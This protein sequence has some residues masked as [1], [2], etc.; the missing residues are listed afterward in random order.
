[1]QYRQLGASSLN[2]SE[3]SL[4]SWRTFGTAIEA[5]TAERC[6][7]QAFDCGINF[8]DTANMYGKGAAEQ[9]LGRLLKAYRRDDY[10]LATKLYFP[11]SETDR[12]LSRAQVLKQIDASLKRL[13]VDHVDLYQC[14]RHDGE[15]PLKETM[16]ALTEIVRAGKVRYVG[17]SEWPAAEIKRAR[18]IDGVVPF[19]SSQ[20]RYSMLYR[21]N[22]RRIFPLCREQ[23]IGQIVWSPLAQG[24]LTGKY[25]PGAA[26]PPGS[27]GERRSLGRFF[28]PRV[29]QAVE[30]LH[31]IARDL[32]LTL[33]QLALAWVL[34]GEKIS[35]AIIGA[36]RPDQIEMNCGASGVNLEPAVLQ[37]IDEVL[38]QVM[39]R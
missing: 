1:M 28:R 33:P 22:E 20:P 18:A 3:I 16:E 31:P 17:F 21:K 13:G 14:H 37:R 24:I 27:R 38:D 29:L 26:A 9:V 19:V 15:T 32:S 10:V 11:M 36:T 6:L 12:G 7:R 23:G 2:V 25:K 4:G 30:K 5:E 35:S 34:R 39:R 8:F